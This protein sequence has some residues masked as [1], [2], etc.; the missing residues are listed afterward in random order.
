[1]SFKQH[2]FLG[3]HKPYLLM[4]LQRFFSKKSEPWEDLIPQT[5]LK[6]EI[7]RF[8]KDKVGFAVSKRCALRRFS[9]NL[10]VCLEALEVF[11]CFKVL[12]TSGGFKRS[13]IIHHILGK[14]C[15]YLLYQ[16]CG[17][18]FLLPAMCS[19]LEKMQRKASHWH[20]QP[21]HHPSPGNPIG[22]WQH[23]RLIGSFNPPVTP[24]HL[25]HPS[26]EKSARDV[27][28]AEVGSTCKISPKGLQNWEGLALR[29]ILSVQFWGKS[30]NQKFHR[31]DASRM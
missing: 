18:N 4:P 12:E 11:S 27:S 17:Y 14:S 25:L 6:E 26:Q 31:K 19:W 21:W 22:G 8:A 30:R 23:V 29:S 16:L 2:V 24:S 20:Q 1:M 9:K 7:H 15:N 13:L 3:A 28:L 10:F 5:E